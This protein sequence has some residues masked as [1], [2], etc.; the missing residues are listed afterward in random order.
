VGGRAIR[1]FRGAAS[2]LLAAVTVG[3]ASKDSPSYDERDPFEPVNRVIF[4]INDTADRIIFRQAAYT[5]ELLVPSVARQGV[6]NF[7]S[8]FGVITDMVN[9]FLQGK[10]R[11]GFSDAARF[12]L[13]FTLGWGG[14]FDPATDAG[15]AK[16]NEDF[17]QTLGVWGLP[18][19]PYLML[20]LLG[21]Q[22]VRS[23]VGFFTVD[24]QTRVLRYDKNTRRRHALIALNIVRIR[25]NLLFLNEQLDRSYDPYVFVRDAILQ[26]QRFLRYDG[27]PPKTK[28]ALEVEELEDQGFED[29]E[30]FE[31]ELGEE[32]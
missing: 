14:L 30:A 10:P 7:Y 18:P 29:F 32:P 26:R 23:T 16:H 6:N 28:K 2:L 24:R 11:A 15:L 9:N 21:P 25:A 27:R 20:P 4:Q 12:T 1:G 5:Y 3:C 17:G 31:E 8:N 13:N 19:G 22:T